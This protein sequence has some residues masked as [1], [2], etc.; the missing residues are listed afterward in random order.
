MKVRKQ[1]QRNW[2][3]R[4]TMQGNSHQNPH[5][6]PGYPRNNQDETRINQRARVINCPYCNSPERHNWYKCGEDLRSIKMAE[7]AKTNNRAQQKMDLDQG[8][9]KN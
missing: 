9:S 5:K 6:N 4:P 7:K 8:T 3:P 1:L 2:S